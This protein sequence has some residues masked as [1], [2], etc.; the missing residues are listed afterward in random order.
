MAR[1]LDIPVSRAS[2][3]LHLGRLAGGIAGGAMAEGLR[4]LGSGNLPT[5]PDL[6]LNPANARRLASRLS[7]MRGAAMKVGQLLSMEGGDFLPPEFTEILGR[8]RDDAHT[9]PMLQVAA[10]LESAWGKHWVKRFDRFF[11]QPI[12]AASIGQVHK[13]TSHDGRNLAIKI[14]YPGVRDSIDSDV[15]NVAALLKFF[16]LIP[17]PDALAV[18]LQDAK[19]QLHEEADYLAEARH[20]EAYRTR[21]SGLPGLRVPRVDTEL[22]TDTVLAMEFV[23]GEPIDALA[24]NAV[25]LRNA[26]ATRLVELFLKEVFEWGLVQTDPNFSNYLYLPDS[27]EVGLLDFGATRRYPQDTIKLY[28]RLLAAAIRGER[29]ALMASAEAVGYVGQGDP[30]LYRSAVSVLIK[31][32]A[33]PA[34]AMGGYDFGRSSLARR[35]SEQVVSLRVENRMWRMPPSEV[36]FLHRKLAGIYLL[37]TRLAASVDVRRL[38][39]PYVAHGA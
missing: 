25:G 9:M 26:V 6:L 1:E 20:I 23:S 19:F 13:A 37:C 17:E 22:T 30:E 3:L 31:A 34:R 32:A 16:R 29:D 35:M 11:F 39:E 12:A 14:Q 10:Q 36:L 2:R 15:D 4:M 7:E 33:E 5:A 27:G 38:V 8:L 18:V 24:R 21:I 28:R